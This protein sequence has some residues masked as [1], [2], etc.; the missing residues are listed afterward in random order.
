MCC[1]HMPRAT[2]VKNRSMVRIQNDEVTERL[3]V[4]PEVGVFI[5]STYFLFC[6]CWLASRGLEE[7]QSPS[8]S[9][10]GN[11]KKTLLENIFQFN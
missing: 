1:T 2:I 4:R 3:A 9:I 10:V 8:D 7:L 5:D 11:L 6:F